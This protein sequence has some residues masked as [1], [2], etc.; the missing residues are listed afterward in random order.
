MKNKWKKIV[1]IVIVLILI[2]LEFIAIFKNKSEV[3]ENAQEKN[4]TVLSN[5][6]QYTLYDFSREGCILCEKMQPIVEKY[7]GVYSNINIEEINIKGTEEEQN[8]TNKYNIQHTPTFILTDSDGNVLEKAQG[9]IGEE[10]FKN[11]LEKYK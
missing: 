2:I 6:S 3:K 10:E 5:S 1:I 9:N 11:I 4:N 8:L 7:K